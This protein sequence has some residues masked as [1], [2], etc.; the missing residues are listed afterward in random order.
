[1]FRYLIDTPS[2]LSF[3]QATFPLLSG[4]EGALCYEDQGVSW[5]RLVCFEDGN[6]APLFSGGILS[7]AEIAQIT[8]S[9]AQEIVAA[10]QGKKILLLQLLEGAAPFCAMV[11]EHLAQ[12]APAGFDYAVAS[13]KISSYLEGSKAQAH[14]VSQPLQ[15]SDGEKGPTVASYD[16]VIILDDLIDAGNTVTW[17]IDEYLPAFRPRAVCAY[18]MLEKKRKRDRAVEAALG[19][20]AAV[21]GKQVPDEWVVGYGLD[22]RLPGGSGQPALHLFRNC[23]PGGVYAFNATIEERLIEHYQKRSGQLA[24]QLR[25]FASDR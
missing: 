13:I 5:P 17:L 14:K 7:F 6:R 25:I 22:I 15:F 8:Q 18:F 16:Q 9:I 20:L 2:L 23:L 12:C 11:C 4:A 24:R 10:Y 1:M 3:D 21:C 19:K